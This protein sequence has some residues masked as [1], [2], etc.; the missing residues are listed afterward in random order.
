MGSNVSKKQPRSKISDGVR[1]KWMNIV[2]KGPTVPGVD[3]NYGIDNLPTWLDHEELKRCQ[4][5]MRKHKF[6]LKLSSVTGLLMLLQF[7]IIVI[8][9]LHTKRSE[10]V[11]NLFSRYLDTIL[12][13]LNW[14]NYDL[15][16]REGEAFKAI[17]RVRRKHVKVSLLMQDVPLPQETL[18]KQ[19]QTTWINMYSMDI[20][21]WAFIGLFLLYPEQCAFRPETDK[22]RQEVLKAINY[23]WR[24]IGYLLGISDEYSICREDYRESQQLCRLILDEVYIPVLT[25]KDRKL[26]PGYFMAKDALTVM[27]ESVKGS[28]ADE[29]LFIEKV[30]TEFM[31]ILIPV[32]APAIL[33]YWFEVFGVPQQEWIDMTWRDWVSFKASKLL[34]QVCSSVS[35]IRDTLDT[36]SDS[37]L[38]NCK[39]NRRNVYDKF[40]KRHPSIKYSLEDYEESKCPFAGNL[41]PSC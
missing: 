15:L 25:C 40:K 26:N 24:T 10:S 29:H 7:P 5:L 3:P 36:T 13:T 1:Q 33:N 21:M 8:P 23:V 38:A 4:T 9:L 31:E 30:L 34:V 11:A 17:E 2:I 41:L 6:S 20:T 32:S 16:D 19:P 14:L 37:K 18:E 27:I 28:S 35:W 12:E 39:K 22:E